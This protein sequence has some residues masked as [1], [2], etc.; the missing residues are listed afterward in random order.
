MDEI[1]DAYFDSFQISINPWGVI[2]NFSLS[3]HQPPSPGSPGENERVA[4]VRTS[5]AHAKAMVFIVR[6]QIMIWEEE[7]A[8]DAQVPTRVLSGMSI[9]PED[10]EGLWK[11]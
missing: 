3:G 2:F 10:W 6:R 4:T 7:N 9:P 8:V 11:R 1:T 5:I